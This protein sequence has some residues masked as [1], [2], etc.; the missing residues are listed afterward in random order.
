[1]R[2]SP[3]ADQYATTTQASH[4][5]KG[6]TQVGVRIDV[7]GIPSV[8][9]ALASLT[10]PPAKKMLQKASSAGGKVLRTY[11]RAEAPQGATGKLKKSVGARIVRRDRPGAVVSARPKVAFY[12]HMVIGGTKAHGPRKPQNKVL[13]FKGSRGQDVRTPWVKGVQ[14]NPFVSRGFDRGQAAA[15]AALEKVV[16]DYLASV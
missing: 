5:Y 1:M 11:V 8:Q 9:K 6:G 16:E 10:G 14:P 3:P 12:R 7:R 15:M 2:Y 13:I 4:G